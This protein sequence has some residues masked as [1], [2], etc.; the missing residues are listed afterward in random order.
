VA[1]AVMARR[2]GVAEIASTLGLPATSGLLTRAVEGARRFTLEPLKRAH[3][4]ACELDARFKMGLTKERE[5]AVAAMLV[6]LMTGA[7]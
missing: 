2:K 4:R 1:A 6:E 3:R 7:A 5:L